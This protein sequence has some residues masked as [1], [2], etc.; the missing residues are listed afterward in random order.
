MSEISSPTSNKISILQKSAMSCVKCA[1]C[2][3]TCT[4]YSVNRDEI[5]SPRGYLD[6]VSAYAE[7]KLSMDL[8]LKDSI[9]SCFLCTTC[10]TQ[11]PM[12]L[13]VDIVIE[14]AR[15]DIA[16]KYGIP[17]YKK[18]LFYML[19]KRSVLNF[20][21]SMGYYFNPCIFKTQDGYKKI[22]FK[23][24]K[25]GDR[26]I[27]PLNK[28]SFLQTYHG[29]IESQYKKNHSINNTQTSNNKKVGIY[30]GCLSNYNYLNVGISLLKILD[31]LGI[32][33][34][35]PQKQE[36][37][38]APAFFSGDIKNTTKL[39]KKNLNYLLPFLEDLDALLIP[40]ATCSAMLLS[41]WHHALEIESEVFGIDNKQYFDKLEVLTK[42][43]F[44]ASKWLHDYT[45]LDEVLKICK[46][47]EVTVTYHDPC[48]ARK[49]L[50]IYQEPRKLL[51]NFTLKEMNESSACCGFGGVTIQS[52]KYHLAKAIGDKKAQNIAKSGANIVSAECSACRMQIDDSL[53]RND[54]H[55]KFMHPLELIANNLENKSNIE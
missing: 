3:P 35:V 20:V 12:S 4:I 54:V 46:K 39:I 2:V 17:F 49:V 13:P 1:K 14:R 8:N 28:K 29:L 25:I 38:G 7:G 43:T 40:E 36:C 31:K 11:C 6:L 26:V 18:I 30:I 5:T 52:E 10:V 19:G 37:C 32:D 55:T 33:A 34:F 48:H 53:S 51:K 45:N 9:E 47:E 50:K 16:Q 42:K 44:M 27:S 22:R 24:P 23:I 15:V 41:D 21:F